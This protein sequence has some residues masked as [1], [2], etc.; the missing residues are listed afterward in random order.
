MLATAGHEG[1]LLRSY[2]GVLERLDR[3]EFEVV[4]LVPP[5]AL[6]HCRQTVQAADVRWVG[7]ADELE[8]AAKTVVEAQCDVLLHWQVDMDTLGYF[9]AFLPL[10]PVQ[11]L[12]FGSHG[13][14]GIANL[15]YCVSSRRF[16]PGDDAGGDYTER[17]VQFTRP[18][19]WQ[20]R[21]APAAP[22]SRE[23]FGLPAQGAL[24][25]CPHRLAK[26]HPDFD[27]LLRRILEEEPDGHLVVLEGRPRPTDA[28]RARWDRTIGKSLANRVLFVPSQRP[29]NYSRMLCLATAVL[30]V[31]T[32]SSCLTGYDALACGVP[33][34]TMPGRYMVQRYV[35]GLYAQM[36]MQDLVA[37]DEEAYVR[38]A[39]ELG[40]NGDFREAMGRQ[41]VERSDV[42]FEDDAVVREYE[43]FF[44][45]VIDER[46]P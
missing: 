40:R 35:A 4:G 12:G 34:V 32:Y 8:R 15:D 26:F 23:E 36:G 25:F 21:P 33:L 20:P 16:E 13:T 6:A 2:G 17:L 44:R 39:V 38:L 41:I 18:H 14:S 46:R 10:A 7:L 29:E 42:L 27:P 19:C 37:A 28:L 3:R 30:D 43:A 31:P 1:G 22:A 45:Q 9:L 5:P 11:C 24:Y